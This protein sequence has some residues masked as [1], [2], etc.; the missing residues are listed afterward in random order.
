MEEVVFWV[1]SDLSMT[2][3]KHQKIAEEA[4]AIQEYRA[5]KQCC[6][7]ERYEA[8]SERTQRDHILFLLQ[9]YVRLEW[10]HL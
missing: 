2:E 8:R 3:A 9:I 6:S 5:I 10:Q 1:T 7:V 4:L